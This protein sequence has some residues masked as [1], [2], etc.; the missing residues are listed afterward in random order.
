MAALKAARMEWAAVILC[1]THLLVKEVASAVGISDTNHF[2]RDF[3]AVHGKTPTDYR[4]DYLSRLA[5][6][7]QLSPIARAEGCE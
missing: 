5:N 2:V 1:A 7:Y 4:Q 6:K 3:K